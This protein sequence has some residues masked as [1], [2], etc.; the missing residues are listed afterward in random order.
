[1]KLGQCTRS[2]QFDIFQLKLL[3]A[4][5]EILH[6]FTFSKKVARLLFFF[7]VEQP[8]R[9]TIFQVFLKN[10]YEFSILQNFLKKVLQSVRKVSVNQ[11]KLLIRKNVFEKLFDY[12][13]SL[14]SY[15]ET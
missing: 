12:N 8:Q 4:N 1:M 14:S 10:H 3:V 9:F 11:S 13:P 15:V 2:H 6:L 5:N 7:L